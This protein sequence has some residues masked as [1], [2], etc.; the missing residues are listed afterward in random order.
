VEFIQF[1]HFSI[2][3]GF[4]YNNNSGC[5]ASYHYWLVLHSTKSSWTKTTNCMCCF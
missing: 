5:L 1:S 3:T 2:F 4:A